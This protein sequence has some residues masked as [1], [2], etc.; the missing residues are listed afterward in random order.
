MGKKVKK[1]KKSKLSNLKQAS[2]KKKLLIGGGVAAIAVAAGAGGLFLAKRYKQNQQGKLLNQSGGSRDISSLNQG[3][4][5]PTLVPYLG[6]QENKAYLTNYNPVPLPDA[7]TIGLGWDSDYSNVNLD[8]LASVFDYNGKSIDYVQGSSRQNIFNGGITHSGDDVQGH[9]SGQGEN[10]LSTILGD[11]EHVTIDFRLVPQ[12]AATIIIGG[13]LVS[14]P[15]GVKNTYINVLPLI[16]ADSVSSNAVQVE[17]D[18]DEGE[19]N[20]PQP[21]SRGFTPGQGSSSAED[22]DDELIL[23]YKAIL[24]Q[25]FVNQRGFIAVKLERTQGGWNLL[26][27][28]QVV[29]IDQQYGLWPSMEYYAK[30]QQQQYNQGYGQQQQQQYNQGAPGAFFPQY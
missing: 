17:Y 24:D 4:V 7:I 2:T 30:P 29:G 22:E 26:P 23:L 25:N 1:L 12:E 11:N 14:A 3:S 13:L 28:R 19:S 5:H 27:V 21:G 16:R 6:L 9:S 10:S 8:L 20:S 18:S 15:H